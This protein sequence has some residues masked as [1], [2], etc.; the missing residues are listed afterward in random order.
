[1]I[2]PLNFENILPYHTLYKT[3]KILPCRCSAIFK[4]DSGCLQLAGKIPQNK[5]SS[6]LV[7]LINKA[8]RTA[9]TGI[10]PAVQFVKDY[11]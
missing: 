2:P 3:Q 11:F 7:L 1:M 6:G 5:I 8:K 9:I 4:T 10:F